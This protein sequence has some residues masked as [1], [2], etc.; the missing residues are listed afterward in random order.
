MERTLAL[1]K[2]DAIAARNAGGILTMIE[3]SG[4]EI[5]AMRQVRLT[6]ELAGRFY[7]V[8]RGKPF[9]D[10]LVEYMSSGPTIAMVLRGENASTRWRE[11]MGA[12]DPA[13][14]A[15]GT[16]RK[17]YG[18]AVNRNATHGSDAPETAR[19]EVAFFFAESALPSE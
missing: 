8:H 4:L 6:A 19:D 13:T 16:I 9:Y 10:G 14:A 2:P 11:L 17:L 1:I 15:E 18:T 7:A 12:T 3:Q 5:V